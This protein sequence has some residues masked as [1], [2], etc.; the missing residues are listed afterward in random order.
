MENIFKRLEFVVQTSEEITRHFDESEREEVTLFSLCML[1]RLN[2]SSES[3]KILM[4]NFNNNSKVEYSCGI[5]I[6]SV[7]LDYLIVLNAHEVYERN[8]E[9]PEKLY[10]ALKDYSI[11]MLC[12]TVRNTLEYLESVKNKFTKDEMQTMYSNLVNTYPECFEVYYN[13]GSKPVIKST[14][15]RSPQKLFDTL[16]KSKSFKKY[17][18]IYEIYLFYS[19]YDHFGQMFYELS[20]KA[21]IGKLENMDRAIKEFPRVLL[22]IVIILET[23]YGSDNFL[24]EKREEIVSFMEGID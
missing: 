3:L 22:F 15:Y 16:M 2:F 4:N 9:K 23:L 6:R 12:D 7:I 13:D 11:M 19:K 14:K 8:F 17:H 20:R 5:I 18:G 21:H 10:Q 24:K 1:D